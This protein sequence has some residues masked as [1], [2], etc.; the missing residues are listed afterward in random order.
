MFHSFSNQCEKQSMLIASKVSSLRLIAKT[1]QKKEECGKKMQPEHRYN[2]SYAHRKCIHHLT[3][4]TQKNCR[5][6]PLLLCLDEYYFEVQNN[7]FM[8]TN[9]NKSIWMGRSRMWTYALFGEFCLCMC[10]FAIYFMYIYNARVLP[11]PVF[12][13]S[14]LYLNSFS[15]HYI[16]INGEYTK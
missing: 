1:F 11:G 10:S 12:M 6:F 16:D 4:S 14:I 13:I 2:M 7:V 15:I 3:N 9:T 5:I 8:N